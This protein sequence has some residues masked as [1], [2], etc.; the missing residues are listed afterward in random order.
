[1]A[2]TK[3]SIFNFEKIISY[4]NYPEWYEKVKIHFNDIPEVDFRYH[5][6]EMCEAVK[7]DEVIDSDIVFIDDSYSVNARSKTIRAVGACNPSLC[8]VHDFENFKYRYSAFLTTRYY[9]FKSLLPNVGVFGID[10][11]ISECKKIDN[12][13]LNGKEFLENNDLNGWSEYFDKHI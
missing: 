4:E 5:E 3:K 6:G 1:M 11:N 2:F 10:L 13:I 7:S 8:V 9:R 12:L